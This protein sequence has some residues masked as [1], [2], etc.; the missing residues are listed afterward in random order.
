MNDFT[1]DDETKDVLTSSKKQ[2]RPT[3][4]KAEKKNKCINCYLTEDEYNQ[5]IEFLEDRPASTFLRKH[6]LKVSKTS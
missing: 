6:I 2:G 4:D 1:F 3:K 5:F